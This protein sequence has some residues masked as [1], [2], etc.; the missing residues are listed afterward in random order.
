MRHI[1]SEYRFV[2]YGLMFADDRVFYIG[3]GS[4]Y[5]PESHITEA[6]SG[7]PCPKCAVIRYAL[8]KR[9]D[10]RYRIFCET[11]DNDYA[12]WAEMKAISSYPY[13]SLCNLWGGGSRAFVAEVVKQGPEL[14]E[15]LI[16]KIISPLGARE[17]I[18]SDMA[19]TRIEAQRRIAPRYDA[20]MLPDYLPRLISKP[21]KI[22]GL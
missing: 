1:K 16:Y 10:I 11:D 17:E 15:G 5:R 20:L 8:S 19:S 6:R 14:Y 3:K 13:G 9:I 7:H 2:V 4:E 12:I 22:R 18:Y 21:K